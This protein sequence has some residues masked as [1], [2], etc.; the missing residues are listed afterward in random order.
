[1][2]IGILGGGQLARMMALAAYPLNIQTRVYEP[3][4]ES[5]AAQVT[6][7]VQGEYDDFRTL[8]QFIQGCDAVT[9]EFENVP[10]ETAHW[11]ADRVPVHPPPEAL[12][13]SQD[14]VIEKNFLKDLGI[15]VPV[16]RAVDAEED[17]DAALKE[18][19]FPCVIKTTRFGYDGKGQMVVRTQA[20]AEK[21]WNL[22]GG[23]P[24]ILEQFIPFEREISM[25]AV[26]DRR[27]VRF[28]PP[29]EN[30]HREGMLRLSQAPAVDFEPLLGEGRAAVDGILRKLDYVGVLTVEFFQCQNR[31]YVNEIA[32]R[33]HNSGHWTI[34]G[35]D[36]SQFENHMRACAGWKLGS[37][38]NR[39]YS[40]MVNL[41][42]HM[43]DADEVAGSAAAHLHHYGKTAKTNRK[44]GHITIC[45]RDA[46]QVAEETG[47]L[48]D[49]LNLNG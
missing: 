33:V 42:G 28:Y 7:R 40:G 22:L 45:S 11:I 21:A 44:L 38:M 30:Q 13:V 35:A 6:E 31:L 17:F 15:R 19:G 16:F 48:I 5:C 1:M 47:Q 24:L 49:R 29:I 26:R 18:I 37:T 25:I 10:L 23:R 36:C 20:D 41:I 8:H 43:P 27:E 32:P 14:R 39:G 3:A 34:E 46:G 12:R 2:K 9:Y 4:Q